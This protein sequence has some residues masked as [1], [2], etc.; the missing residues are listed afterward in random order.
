MAIRERSRLERDPQSDRQ[1][2]R[3]S[4]RERDNPRVLE[5]RV[6]EST[7]PTERGRWELLREEAREGDRDTEGLGT[8]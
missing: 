5:T 2:Q 3:P 8:R 4:E 6:T 7:V 1:A